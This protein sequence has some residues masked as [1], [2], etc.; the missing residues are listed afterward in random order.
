[1]VLANSSSP[2]PSLPSDAFGA[3]CF[4]AVRAVDDLQ[5][6]DLHWRSNTVAFPDVGLANKV[7]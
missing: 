2:L 1:M 7:D 3:A 4:F 6:I 5:P